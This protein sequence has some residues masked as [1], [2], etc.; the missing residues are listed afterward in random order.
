MIDTRYVQ[1]GWFTRNIF[2]RGVRRLTRMGV[3]VAGSR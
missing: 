3:S 1:P 2:N